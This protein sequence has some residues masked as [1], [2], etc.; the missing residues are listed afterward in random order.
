MWLNGM[1]RRMRGMAPVGTRRLPMDPDARARRDRGRLMESRA[2]GQQSQD[3]DDWNDSTDF[4]CNAPSPIPFYLGGDAVQLL[5]DDRAQGPLIQ[6]ATL[7]A[8]PPCAR[9]R[10]RRY[11]AVPNFVSA[12]SY[13]APAA[14]A[15]LSERTLLRPLTAPD[16]R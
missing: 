7:A 6:P 14:R 10:S 3:S 2:A 9:H 5:C 15:M 4:H 1:P 16:G 12:F 11:L 13:I 8:N